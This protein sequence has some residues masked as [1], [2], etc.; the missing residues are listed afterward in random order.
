MAERE[1]ALEVDEVAHRLQKPVQLALG[2]QP[3]AVGR[4]R[5]RRAPDVV[6]QP[7]KD[8]P[9]AAAEGGGDGR[10][11]LGAAAAARHPDSTVHPGPAQVHLGDIRQL[12]HAHLHRNGITPGTDGSPPPSQRSKVYASASRTSA[13]S[14]TRSASTPAEAQWEWISSDNRP[15]GATR[16][17]TARP[18]RASS[19][20]PR[21]A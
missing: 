8:L 11:E 20:R 3:V 16:N 2:Q 6:G 10:V 15:R 5:Q 1:R 19:G 21:P 12:H 9:S 14:P 7:V 17:D 18:P 4:L 13:A